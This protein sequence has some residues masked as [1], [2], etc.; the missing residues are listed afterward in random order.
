MHYRGF[1][2]ALIPGTIKNNEAA[3]KLMRE[4]A[5]T[6]RLQDPSPSLTTIDRGLVDR[7]RGFDKGATRGAKGVSELPKWPS[8]ASDFN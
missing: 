4:T 7:G 2:I 6:Q 5:L 1:V 8:G 3:Q